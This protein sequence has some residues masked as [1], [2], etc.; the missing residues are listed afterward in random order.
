MT[1]FRLD[2]VSP[3]IEQIGA[4]LIYLLSGKSDAWTDVIPT[5]VGRTLI[6]FIA[7]TGG[8]AQQSIAASINE[9][10]LDPARTPNAIYAMM[11]MLGVR[12]QRRLPASVSVQLT[13]T[14]TDFVRIPEFSTWTVGGRPFYNRTD[15]LFNDSVSTGTAVLYSGVV[16]RVSILSQGGD[17]QTFELGQADFSMSDQ[18][19]FCL[20]NG[21]I[22]KRYERMTKGPWF[23][24][25]EEFL[26]FERTTADGQ[27]E[28]IFGN[29]TFG[30]KPLLGERLDFVFAE[31]GG[32]QDNAA[33]SNERV[34]VTGNFP[35][36]GVTTSHVTGGSG[37]KNHEYYRLF[38]PNLY[39]AKKGAVTRSDYRAIATTYNG[40]IDAA[41]RGQAET[42]PDDARRCNVIEYTLLTDPPFDDGQHE[43]FV[44]YMLDGE[45]SQW[46]IQFVRVDPD[47]VVV[48]V[49]IEVRCKPNSDAAKV[50]TQV[51]RAIVLLFGIRAGSL[52]F[53]M[54]QSY[55]YEFINNI[56]DE[57]EYIILNNPVGDV[58]VSPL[59][60]VTLGQLKV[61]VSYTTQQKAI[62]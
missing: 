38:G 55:I 32:D 23:M 13:K 31:T 53:A 58:L 19:I 61:S 50:K 42:A 3:D 37:A 25:E 26:F 59:E 2:E 12:V 34:S 10:Y 41:F 57:V 15:I 47:P 14:G 17:F 28:I 21:D 5:G 35:V 48:D 44:S 18:D 39:S 43:R 49:D 36:T 56:L 1:Q 52:G 8:Y 9:A 22:T 6:D 60:Y 27:A 29:G 16:Q 46:G 11:R 4:Q 7:L 40:V 20:I 33:L 30:R 51:E 62:F 54:A 45:K 24:G